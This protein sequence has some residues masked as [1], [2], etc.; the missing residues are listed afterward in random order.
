MKTTYL[1]ILC[2]ILALT[3][4]IQ[5]F[6]IARADKK[7]SPET[8]SLAAQ[9][10]VDTAAIVQNCILTRSSVRS[11]TDTPLTDGQMDSLVRA[12]MAAPTAADKRPWEI[13][14]ITDRDIL[15]AIAERFQTM[16]M[17]K[18]AT[19]AIVICGDTANTL[20]G[21]GATY[22]IQDCS[23]ATE[24]LLLSAHGMGLGAVWCGIYPIS[25][26]VEDFSALL[27][28]PE[29]IIPLSIVALGHPAGPTHPKEKYNP[30]KLHSQQW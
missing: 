3:V 14:T 27:D 24:N 25:S 30:A 10:T 12:A 21:E 6:S 8:D 2:A 18:S 23:A 20:D 29:H 19:A 15:N 16:T 7:S 13:I 1:Y 9:S 4:L 11:F 26:R 5:A 17:M 22:W 28:L